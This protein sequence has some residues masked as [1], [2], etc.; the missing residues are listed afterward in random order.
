[1]IVI[2]V[3]RAINTIDRHPSGSFKN[4]K[5]SGVIKFEIPNTK[6][7]LKIL[8]P[9]RFPRASFTWF[10]FAEIIDAISSGRLVEMATKVNPIAVELIPR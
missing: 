6:K 4:S 8:L 5:G 3:I 9:N 1:M 2:N 10:D 7:T